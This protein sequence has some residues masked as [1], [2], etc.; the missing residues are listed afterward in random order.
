MRWLGLSVALSLV[1]TGCQAAPVRSVL[2]ASAR[3]RIAPPVRVVAAGV[4]LQLYK[5]DI[6]VAV[7]DPWVPEFTEA[8]RSTGAEEVVFRF[9]GSDLNDE[10]RDRSDHLLVGRNRNV[11]VYKQLRRRQHIIRP[12][13]PG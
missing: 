8:L 13:P 3:I 2:N 12:P 10:L 7:A 11:S 1:W 6:P 5:A 4:V 9:V